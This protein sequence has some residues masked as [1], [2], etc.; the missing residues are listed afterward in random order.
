MLQS[1]LKNIHILLTSAQKVDNFIKQL[2]GKYSKASV[3]IGIYQPLCIFC[4]VLVHEIYFKNHPC[5]GGG[6]NSDN[7]L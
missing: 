3:N 7:W 1:E 4:E 6:V 2:L 5:G